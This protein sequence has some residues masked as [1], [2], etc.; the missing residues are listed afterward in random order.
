MTLDAAPT[1]GNVLVLVTD[2]TS[3]QI[4]GVTE[5]NVAWT[6]MLTMN[7]GTPSYYAIWIG[8][9]SASGSATITWTKPGS[10]CSAALIEI[11]GSA[12]TPTLG[13]NATLASTTPSPLSPVVAR[14][15][16]AATTSGHLVVFGGGHDNTTHWQ[17]LCPSIPT[18]GLLAGI[19]E[20]A[21]G[22]AQGG[23]VS[24]NAIPDTGISGTPTAILI[25]EIT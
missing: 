10:F 23:T 22:L 14:T 12:V 4:T 1:T 15:K 7:T 17:E 24:C 2:A 25:A 9:V 18:V 16:I 6:Q 13:N 8:K 5:T 20:V 3:G 21:V 19:V 11:S